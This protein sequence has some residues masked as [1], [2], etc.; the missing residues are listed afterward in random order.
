[1][2]KQY[3]TKAIEYIEEHFPKG[4]KSRGYAMCLCA[5]AFLEGKEVLKEKQRGKVK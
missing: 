4:H 1:M 3:P 2:K 5:I